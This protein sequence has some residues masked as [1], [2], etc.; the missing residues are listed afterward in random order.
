MTDHRPALRAT[1]ILLIAAGL[2]LS[3]Q[4]ASVSAQQALIWTRCGGPIGGLGYDVRM[5]PT[6]P[7]TMF[8]TDSFAGV[9]RSFDGGQNWDPVNDGI[10]IRGGDSGDAIKVFCLTIDPVNHNTVWLG[11]QDQ[12]GIYKSTDLGENWTLLV[13]GI[14]ETVGL[15]FRGISIDPDHPDTVY[16]AGEL[17]STVWADTLVYGREFDKTMGVVYKTLDGGGT[18]F[19]IWRGDNLARYV[20]I[21]PR[22]TQTLYLSTGIM[23]RE[24]ANSGH[25][26]GRAWR[27]GCPQVNRWWR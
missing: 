23:D 18:W 22:D 24:A 17:S 13:N 27:S 20:L 5:H 15:S 14:V 9:F 12:R 11:L 19:E 2:L 25:N 26:H 1:R 6:C 7:D 4:I 16:A 8:V 10:N 21:D 3:Q